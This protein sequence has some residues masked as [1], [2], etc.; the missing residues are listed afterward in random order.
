[1]TPL[2]IILIITLYLRLV[3]AFNS[4]SD[5][6]GL[7]IVKATNCSRGEEVKHHEALYT[8]L[9]AVTKEFGALAKVGADVKRIIAGW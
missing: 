6:T 3:R 1:M 9:G 8:L 2:M 4:S 5:P 7:A